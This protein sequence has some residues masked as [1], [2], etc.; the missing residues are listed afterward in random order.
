MD[1]WPKKVADDIN[2]L[3]TD[4]TSLIKRFEIA[5][6]GASRFKG[7]QTEAFIAEINRF[8]DT[9]QSAKKTTA[10][11]YNRQLEKVAQKQIDDLKSGKTFNPNEVRDRVDEF[12]EGYSTVFLMMDEGA[13]TEDDVINKVILD[14]KDTQKNN[15]R[16]LMDPNIRAIGIAQAPIKGENVTIIALADQA[17]EKAPKVVVKKVVKVSEGLEDLK[18]AF[19]LFDIDDDGYIKPNEVITALR[20]VGY[21]SKSPI[22]FDILEGLEEDKFK[23]LVDFET[24]CDYINPS[25][26]NVNSIDGLR[27]LFNLFI[28]DPKQD[29]ITVGTLRKIVREIS[30][31]IPSKDLE[32]MVYRTSAGNEI[33]FEEFC[34]FMVNKYG[35]K[36][37]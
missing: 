7:K 28:D 37:D 22:L 12:A 24:F 27:R 21:N 6:T 15:R 23:G 10:M 32:E 5:R 17:R 29:T 8:I 30:V 34:D 4:P 1:S 9:L 14:K 20:A 35:L 3:R 2:V 11:T 36:L 13:S 19:D 31:N 33:T 25:I 18:I 26:D 16:Y